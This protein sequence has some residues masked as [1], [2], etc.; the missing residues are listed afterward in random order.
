M[1]T[2]YFNKDF[3]LLL[4]YSLLPG[5]YKIVGNQLLMLFSI[6]I[7]L[8]LINKKNRFSIFKRFD[9][10]FFFYV[11][12]ILILCAIQYFFSTTNKIGMLM[13][14]FLDV[15]PMAGYFYSRKQPFE[16]FIKNLL[17]IGIIHLVIGILLYPLFGLNYLLGD[18]APILLEGV[19]I[20]RM[21]SVSGSLGF[22]SLMFMMSIGALYYN[23][24]LFYVLLIGVICAAQR[25]GWLA[26]VAGCLFYC[27]MSVKDG[28]YSFMKNWIIGI[29]IF[30]TI[31]TFA[32]GQVDLDVSYFSERIN[33]M[34]NAVSERDEQWLSAIDNF[35]KMPI[36]TGSGQVGQVA[37]RYEEGFYHIVPD[38]DYFRVLSEYGI[39]GGLFYIFFLLTLVFSISASIKCKS[40]FIHRNCLLSI[41]IGFSIQMIGSNITEF[42]FNNF[43]YWTF[44]GYYFY[45]LNGM[46]KI[47]SKY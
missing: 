11:F 38:G 36:G 33:D 32:I 15:I 30:V 9:L 40:S 20:A 17:P 41:F 28:N 4:V 5:I 8:L 47:N 43:L 29:F 27:L 34:G 6:P 45:E 16:N 13:G 10:F 18:I 31:L 37:A 44:V 39:G 21:S 19:S 26:C 12:Y 42:Y 24:K 3:F 23:R 25:S 14:I 46:L 2:R 7:I 1:H 22:A 35:I